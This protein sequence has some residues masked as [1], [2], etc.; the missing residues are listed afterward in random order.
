MDDDHTL[1]SRFAKAKDERAFTELVRRHLDM[2]YGVCLRRTGNRPLAEELVQNVF[3]SL[4]RKAGS[5]K[6]EVLVV[7]WLHRAAHFESL[8]AFRSESSRLR[9]M[10]EFMDFQPQT[11][12][13]PNSFRE[14][15]P[16]L[17]QALDALPAPD[18]DVVLLRF[19]SDLTLQQ[20][21]HRLGKSESAAQR[22]LQRVLDKLAVILRR[23]GV[24]TS[25][26]ALA[27][28]LGADFAKAAPA[29]LTVA[30]V[31]KTAIA[32]A[33]ASGFSIVKITT[34]LYIMKN[35]AIIIA[36]VCLLAAGGSVAY[37][38]T[39]PS[40]SLSSSSSAAIVTKDSATNTGAS[41][42]KDLAS[43]LSEETAK[44]SASSRSRPVSEYHDLEEK[45]GASRVRL[46]KNVTDNFLKM[47]EGLVKVQ[48]LQLSQE[49]KG[50]KNDKHINF[51]YTTGSG[52]GDSLSSVTGLTLSEEQK[53]KVKAINAKQTAKAIDACRAMQ[54]CFRENRTDV[55]ELL[56]SS[57]ASMRGEMSAGN[58]QTVLDQKKE[59]LLSMGEMK[60]DTCAFH[61]E[62]YRTELPS[63]LD[64]DQ[65]AVFEKFR[66]EQTGDAA[67]GCAQKRSNPLNLRM[68]ADGPNEDAQTL[69][70][71]DEEARKM[72]AIM[73][74]LVKMLDA[75]GGN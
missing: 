40:A 23:R 43:T 62:A 7:G 51:S 34:I 21:G 74:G 38:S 18:R 71:V 6:P 11:E 2:V 37:I 26:T 8:S 68:V 65:M 58:Y 9:K 47:T 41:S 20:I 5:L 29:S 64:A 59:L 4:A 1:L 39:R 27:L 13:E 10:K 66:S 22:H 75:A 54:A 49:A 70:Q 61:S 55:M 35:K 45:F 50:D 28:M 19:A 48:E 72:V 31:S 36:S 60:P 25:A 17:D 3:A 53:T 57:D 14:I 30:F 12:P 56:L 33:A 73:G 42:S 52:T 63:I 67:A 16:F 46:A 32:S 15:S 69:E 44:K 24:T